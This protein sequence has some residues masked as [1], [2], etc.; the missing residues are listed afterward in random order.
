MKYFYKN[1]IKNYSLYDAAGNVVTKDILNEQ[2]INEVITS[3][4]NV[5]NK[6]ATVYHKV[7]L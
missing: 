6:L 1:L 2:M 4:K 5:I 3:F 7:S